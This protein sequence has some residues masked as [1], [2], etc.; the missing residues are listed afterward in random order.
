M[1]RRKWWRDRPWST[2]PAL[3]DYEIAEGADFTARTVRAGFDL[4]PWAG[5]QLNSTLNQS[6]I[7]ENG[8]HTYAQYGLS[9]A[10]PIGERW[11]VDATSLEFSNDRGATW[12]YRPTPDAQGC[13]A[14]VTDIRV[15]IGERSPREARPRCA[16][17]SWL[18]DRILTWSTQ[19]GA[20]FLLFDHVQPRNPVSP[21]VRDSRSGRRTICP[22]DMPDAAR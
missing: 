21:L 16:F 3:A 10:V 9:Q 11:T 4:T 2:S 12:T 8:T 14:A 13:A 5:A 6:A 7:S 15:K 20:S 19:E 1:P 17:G 22:C 18:N